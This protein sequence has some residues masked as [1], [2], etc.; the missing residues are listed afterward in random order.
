MKAMCG[1]EAERADAAPCREVVPA[2]SPLDAAWAF[3]SVRF[4]RRGAGRLELCEIAS[5]LDGV[6]LSRA[7]FERVFVGRAR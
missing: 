7:V 5:G 2:A 1:M 4:A 3:G 6:L